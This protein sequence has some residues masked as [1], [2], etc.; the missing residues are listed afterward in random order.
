MQTT[1]LLWL[2]VAMRCDTSQTGARELALALASAHMD[3]AD[4][5]YVPAECT[6]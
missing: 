2:E 4:R 3:A 5:C 6:E 1:A